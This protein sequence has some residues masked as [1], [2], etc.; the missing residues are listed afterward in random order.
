MRVY[1]RSESAGF[2]E[3]SGDVVAEVPE[4]EGGTAK[5]LQSSVNG[6]VWSVTFL[7]FG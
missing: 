5:V 1:E 7:S 3:R 6:F 2:E 4:A